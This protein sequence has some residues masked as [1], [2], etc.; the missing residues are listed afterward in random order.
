MSFPDQTVHYSMLLDVT[1]SHLKIS[2]LGLSKIVTEKKAPA[3]FKLQTSVRSYE[4]ELKAMM[5]GIPQ[6]AV[7]MG[8]TSECGTEGYRAPEIFSPSYSSAIDTFSLGRSL[9]AMIYRRYIQFRKDPALFRLPS[10]TLTV[11]TWGASSN[12]TAKVPLPAFIPSDELRSL[13]GR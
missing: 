3:L 9:W 11:T 2:D 12:S 4:D 5:L 13:A 6:S 8:M 1:K 10:D 7:K